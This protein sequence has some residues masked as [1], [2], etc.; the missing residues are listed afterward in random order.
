MAKDLAREIGY[1]Y[2]DTGSMYRSLTYLVLR[3]NVDIYSE[4]KVLER[5][6]ESMSIKDRGMSKKEKK[7]QAKLRKSQRVTFKL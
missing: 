5:E 3:D 7:K 6:M 1:V 4:E 2:I